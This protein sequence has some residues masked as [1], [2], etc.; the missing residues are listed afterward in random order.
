[1]E[2]ELEQLKV[3]FLAL[4]KAALMSSEPDT[5]QPLADAV[6]RVGRGRSEGQTVRACGRGLVQQHDAQSSICRHTLIVAWHSRS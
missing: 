6:L 1:M 3:T 5:Y 2:L 4:H